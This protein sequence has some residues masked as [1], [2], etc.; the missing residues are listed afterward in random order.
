MRSRVTT[1][2]NGAAVTRTIDDVLAGL[3]RVI[4]RALE[5]GDRAGYFAVLYRKVTAKVKEGIAAGFFDDPARMERLDV[6]FADRY[7]DAVAAARADEAVTDAWRL[8]FDAAAR[9]RSLILQHLLVGINAHINLDLG[10]AAARCAPGAELPG[11]RRDY[12]RVNA[13]LAA[14]IASVQEDLRQ[15]SPWLGLLDRLGARTQSEVIRFSIVTARAGAWRFAERLAG[16]AEPRWDTMIVDRDRRV[17][18][19]GQRIL[20]PGRWTGAG[21]WLVRLRERDDV[22]ANLQVLLGAQPPSLEEVAATLDRLPDPGPQGRS[23]SG[24]SA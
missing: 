12:D 9:G 10:V 19:V 15:V 18:A 24:P 4:A 6:L 2:S 16:T 1:A 5:D 20:R 14:M 21:L 3:D 8:T 13:T 22:R 17:A 7:L 23:P 11:L